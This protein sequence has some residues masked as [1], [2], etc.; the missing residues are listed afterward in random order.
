MLPSGTLTFLFT[1]IEGSTQRWDRDRAAMQAAVRRHDAI[2][3]A[4]IER[5]GGT[6][7][8]T[9]GDAFCAVFARPEEGVAAALEA[10]RTL[11]RED[12]APVDGLRVRMALHTGT[13]DEREGDYY[14]P[15]LNRVARLLSIGHGGQTLISRVTAHIVRDSLPQ[16][17]TLRELGLHKLKDLAEPELVHQLD[18]PELQH[19]FA[20]LRS[21]GAVPN[22][23]P[24]QV[25]SFVGRERE[26]A[27][28]L[29]LLG[30]HRLVTLLG[31]G[32]I[33]KTRLSL[34]VASQLLDSFP[35]GVWFV[36][37]APVSD[38][39]LVA[40]TVASEVGAP[41]APGRP[42]LQTLAA[43]L[44]SQQAL[45]VLDNCEHL[46]AEI[47]R[48]V[49]ALLK[50]CPKLKVFASSRELLSVPGEQ[51]YRM[52]TL[53]ANEAIALFAERAKT[54]D[55]RFSLTPE[56]EPVVAEICKRLDGIA[57]AIE[58]A[59]ARVKLLSVKALLEK[60]DDRFRVLTGGSRTLLPRQQTLRALIDWSYD[61]LSD[62]ERTLFRRLSIFS[63]GFTLEIAG[64]VCAA[65]T[66]DEFEVM[67]LV[68]AL[69]DKSLVYVEMSDGDEKRYTLLESIREYSKSKL[70]ES[71]EL[72]VL[73]GRHAA[74]FADLAERYHADFETMPWRIW[75]AKAR[76]ELENWRSAITWSL[77]DGKDVST[78][79]R[80]VAELRPFWTSQAIAEGRRWV[81]KALEAFGEDRD[82]SVFADLKLIEAHVALQGHEYEI[83][84][85]AASEAL[86]ICQKHSEPRRIAYAQFCAGAASGMR[87]E[88]ERA[89]SLLTAA[90]EG[91]RQ[92]GV[93]RNAG[94]AL[95]FLA[96]TYKLEG[97]LE[98]AR[99]LFTQALDTIKDSPGPERYI[100]TISTLLAEIEFQSGATDKALQLGLA[101]LAG[102]REHNDDAAIAI[103]LCNVA[104]YLLALNRPH[105][106]SKY[107]REALTIAREREIPFVTFLAVGHFAAIAAAVGDGASS[108]HQLLA[109][110]LLGFVDAGLA[111]IGSVREYTEQTEYEQAVRRLKVLGEGP[112]SALMAEGASW[113]QTTATDEA[114]R[115]VLE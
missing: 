87:G 75:N 73:A 64:T 45:I 114:L 16:G 7:F 95:Q 85:T 3:R 108:E 35:A 97:D 105:E 6:V 2:L 40:G 37:L 93:R 10:Q 31:T 34:H 100:A 38:A 67:E 43:H 52:P 80:I 88:S 63:G 50:G 91:F 102:D 98:T 4:A 46:V 30:E 113:S 96:L 20:P 42:P 82:T 76:L 28:V 19:E 112:L 59:A 79:Q 104:A 90:V 69:V 77:V 21:A 9:I 60:L 12:F 51:A 41:E 115:L 57:L 84:A 111:K 11:L 68:S 99:G 44:K 29:A 1:D 89:K 66:L 24:A 8:K 36:E 23:L 5:S 71:G 61:L 27:E 70:V 18:A 25:S 92:A 83:A 72:D 78:G 55:Q 48:V 49:D 22:N 26:S 56:N 101:A 74:A 107:A 109:A 110:K 65:E 39:T 62:S 81:R 17:A 86:T 15:T 103:D 33:G 106:A 54:A 53:S 32:G 14:G 58:L 13:A 94:A 47:A